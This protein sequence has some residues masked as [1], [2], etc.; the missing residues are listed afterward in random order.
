MK[1]EAA[2]RIK[3]STQ[4][5]SILSPLVFILLW[6]VGVQTK[7]LDPRFYPQPSGIIKSLIDLASSGELWDSLGISLVRV[8]LGFLIAA[9]PGIILGLLIGIN[10]VARAIINPLVAALNPIPKIALIPFVVFALKFT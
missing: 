7:I 6:E 1:S 2:M 10:P 8:T 9:V 5:L 4:W 3:F